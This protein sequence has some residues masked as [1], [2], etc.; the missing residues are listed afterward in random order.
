MTQHPRKVVLLDL[1]GTLTESAPG[2]LASVKKTFQAIDM[3]V[4]DDHELQQFIGPAIIESLQR[5]HVPEDKLQLAVDTYRSYYSDVDAFDDPQEPGA[6]VPGKFVNVIY[7]G[8]IDQLRQLRAAGY[9]LAIATCKPEYQAAPICDHFHLNEEVDGLYGASRDMTRLNKDQVIRYAFDA[10]GFD[11]SQGDIAIMVGDRWT[12]VDGAK[13]VG[14]AS[15][16]CNWGYANPG[17]LKE[18]GVTTTIDAV[19]DLTDAVN[20]LFAQLESDK[21]AV[22]SQQTVK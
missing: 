14:I 6:K 2:I 17:E 20:D 3:P 7:P 22:Q 21:P 19:R 8:I 4:P 18:H 5:N 1:D 9:Y 13:A 10:I 16:G 12:D 11:E 15:I